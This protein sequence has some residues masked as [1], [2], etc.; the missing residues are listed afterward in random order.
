MGWRA[1]KEVY[2]KVGSFSPVTGTCVLVSLVE[3][4]VWTYACHLMGT[5]LLVS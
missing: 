4:Y 3:T 5:C 2:E 1:S